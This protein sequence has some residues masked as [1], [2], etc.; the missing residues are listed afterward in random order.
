MAPRAACSMENAELHK[1]KIVSEAATLHLSSPEE[2][3]DTSSP[4]P[5]LYLPILMVLFK[6]FSSDGSQHILLHLPG[7]LPQASVVTKKLNLDNLSSGQ[8]EP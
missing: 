4:T 2:T 5:I 1:I 6:W 7:S 8:T 3:E